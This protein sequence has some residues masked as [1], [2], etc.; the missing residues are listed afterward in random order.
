[1][2]ARFHKK[3]GRR[4]FVIGLDCGAPELIFDQWR[5]RLPNFRRLANNGLYG[6]L[7]STIPC[8]TVPAWSSM[9]SGKDPGTLGFYGFR[10]RADR[11]YERMSIATGADVKEQRVWDLVGAAGKQSVIVGV[12]QTYPVRPLNGHL[13]SSFLTP[14]TTNPRTQWTY[15]AE[16]REEVRQI[17][18]DETYDVDVPQFRTDDKPFLLEQIYAMTDKRF[19]VL[20]HLLREKPWDLFMF[21]EMGVD[22]IHHGFWGSMDKSHP[23]YTPGGPYEDAILD[24]TVHLDT[25]VGELLDQLA[26]DTVVLVVSDH[27]AK[28]MQGG[29]C[30]NEWLRR[31]G[32]LVLWEEP[33]GENVVP[34]E[35]AE[36]DWS[37]TKAWGAGGYYGRIFL[38]VQGRE[39]Q[40]IIP[41]S[42]YE[43]ERDE[44]A[45][46]L[47]SIPAPDGSHLATVT[48]KPEEVYTTV[49]NIPPDLITYFGN[50]HWRSVGSFGHG[51]IYTLENDL[52]PDDAN[53][54][55][56]GMFILFDPQRNYGGRRVEGLHVMDV[57]PTILDV[58]GLPIPGDVQGKIIARNE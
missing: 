5:D 42:Q 47:D 15:P 30:I 26:D 29:I 10:N 36:V 13:I 12:P 57:A 21:V 45:A 51:G 17:L 48:Y 24:Y 6:D 34:F 56:N 14:S 38:N 9:L 43:K 37:R 58:M 22:R 16:L 20:N 11:S 23:R 54:A 8:I 53:H 52:G 2:L 3:K 25:L 35:K 39:P 46:R 49:R 18:G 33:R 41:T 50:L 32:Y 28:A 55:A 31:E 4:V 44:L 19:R 1:M 27:G 40:G 7:M